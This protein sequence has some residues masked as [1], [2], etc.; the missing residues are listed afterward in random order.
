MNFYD[1]VDIDLVSDKNI[2]GDDT[3]VGFDFVPLD[4][5][6]KDGI[7]DTPKAKLPKELKNIKDPLDIIAYPT[8]KKNIPQRPMMKADIIP[9]HPSAVIFN[10]KSGSGKT[11]LMVNLM[12]RPEF[13]GKTDKKNKKS[14]YFDVIFLFSP[15]ANGGDDLVKFLEIPK[16]RIFTDFDKT[17]LD[18]ILDLQNSIVEDKGL[19]KSPKMLI[20]FEDIQ[21]DAKFMANKSFLRCY[22]QGRHMNIS[23]FLCGQSWTLTPRKCRLQANNIFFFPSSNS[24]VDILLKEFCPPHTSKEQ[25]LKMIKYATEKPYNFLHINMRK[26]P[27]ERFRHNLKEIIN[28][29]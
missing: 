13:Y 2:M 28:P 7:D 25:F 11:N 15:T 9:R 1:N 26:P 10:G 17:K 8:N 6:E 3:K 29:I 24:E 16:K 27:D 12:S 21:S 22:I 23:T 4:E 5:Y 14:K 18:K 19:D 20:I